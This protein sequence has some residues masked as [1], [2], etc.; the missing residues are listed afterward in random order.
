MKRVR[1]DGVR[2]ALVDE[3]VGP[4]VLFLH[5]FPDSSFLWRHQVP[6]LVEGGLPRARADL[7]GFGESDRPDARGSRSTRITAQ[8]RGRRC[9]PRTGSG[10]S[11]RTSLG[12]TTARRSRGCSPGWRQ[13][14]STGWRCFSVGHPNTLGRHPSVGAAGE[15][16]GTMLLFLFE[17]TAEELFDAGRLGAAARVLSRASGD[18]EAVVRRPLAS[19][20]VDR[21][22]ELVPRERARVESELLLRGPFPG[23]RCADAWPLELGRQLPARGGDALPRA[24][25]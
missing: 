18:Q 20:G 21:G 25:T 8:P 10:S 14:G 22:A 7:R 24:S 19:R 16:L 1:G 17:G 12:T 6:A 23:D 9:D 2:L 11:G 3:G 4:A 13:S 5:G 15:V